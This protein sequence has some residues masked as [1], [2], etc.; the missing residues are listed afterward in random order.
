MEIISMRIN[1]HYNRAEIKP[2][3]I[4]NTICISSKINIYKIIIF[5]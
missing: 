2:S 1:L 4:S 3:I 5:Y